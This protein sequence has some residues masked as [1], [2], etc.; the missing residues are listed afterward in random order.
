M[1]ALVCHAPVVRARMVNA[2]VFSV[3]LGGRKSGIVSIPAIK[4]HPL[5][6][7]F[8]SFSKGDNADESRD[9]IVGLNSHV[10]RAY[11][12][13]WGPRRDTVIRATFPE[14]CLTE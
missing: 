12:F 13:L 11:N 8:W 6:L 10:L 1:K 3:R 2:P 9:R 7:D 5:L 14:W 4:P